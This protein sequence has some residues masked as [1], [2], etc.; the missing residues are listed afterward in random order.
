MASHHYL[1]TGQRTCHADDGHEIPC[2]ST[3]QDASFAAGTPWPEHRFDLRDDE[4][5]DCLTGLIKTKGVS[6]KYFS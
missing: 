6:I 3:G 1:H 5:M 2:E 4:V